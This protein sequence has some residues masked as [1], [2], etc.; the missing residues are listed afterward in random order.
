M[1]YQCP[2]PLAEAMEDRI[3]HSA[4]LLPAGL[5]ADG[6]A[7]V[8]EQR[9]ELPAQPQTTVAALATQRQ[10][11]FVDARA[12]AG[13]PAGWA[14]GDEV[15][16][17]GAGEDGLARI[18][19][20]LANRHDL[21][22]VHLLP[23]DSSGT[24]R[25]GDTPFDAGTLLARAAEVAGWGDA[26]GADGHLVLHRQAAATPGTAA[27]ATGMLQ[28]DLA[29][30]TGANV[31]MVVDNAA[32]APA[33][34][35]VPQ[36]SGRPPLNFET[37]LGQA[38]AG[39]DF[40]AR[41]AGY[42]LAL[43]DGNAT[44]QLHAGATSAT[45][46]MALVGAAP[47]PA[48]LAEGAITSR[49]NYLVGAPGQ[50]WQNVENH[51]SVRYDGVYDG[52]DLRYY[53]S[54]QQLEYDFIVGAGAD[55]RQIALRFDGAEQVAIDAD[56]AL[57]LTLAGGGRALFHAPVSYQDGA[58]G[59]EVVASR[60]LL[61]ADGSVGFEV[62]AYDHTRALVIDP[63]LA[64]GTYFGDAGAEQM[65]G[66]ALGADGTVYLA[67]SDNGDAVVVK[68]SADL[69]SVVYTTYIG[70]GASDSANAIAVDAA[71]Q[72]YIA[73]TTNSP[74]F[75]GSVS[76]GTD[77]F[78]AKLSVD[79]SSLLY[80]RVVS[81]GL[82]DQGNGIAVDASG[83]AYLVA[84][85]G[86][87]IA[88]DISVTKFNAAGSAA[89]YSFTIAG[90]GADTGLAIAV[91]GSGR[92]AIT[93]HTESTDLGASL[94][95]AFNTSLGNSHDAY[96]FQLNA[97]GNA[98]VYGTLFGGNQTDTGRAITYGPGGRIYIT[99]DTDSTNLSTTSGAFQTSF[100]N[101]IEAFV[102]VFDPALSG[103][104]TRV[105]AT[106]LSGNG[107][108]IGRAIAV[109]G[110]G[111]IFVAGSTD[112]TG[113]TVTADRAQGSNGGL[114]DG[115]FAILNPAGAGSADLVYRSYLGGTG[116][117]DAN[118]LALGS[119]KVV[120]AG[121]SASATGIAR[122]GGADTSFAGATDGFA[123]SFNLAATLIVD[124]NNDLI[125]GNVS[126]IAALL[127][128]RGADGKVSL[129][130][131]ITAANNTAN[132]AGGAD[133]ILF[134]I[135]AG[136]LQ[137]INLGST[138]PDITQALVIDGSSQGGWNGAPLIEL[139]GSGADG[140]NFGLSI[141]G[142]GSTV[143]G[144]VINQFKSG[145]IALTGGG[146]NLIAGNYIGL[147]A[148]GT[149][150]A[151]NNKDG[152][153]I[154]SA[155]NTIGGTTAADRNVISG[156]GWSG[157]E[158]WRASATG[159]II[160]GNYIG[161][162]AAGTAALG[163]NDN[164]IVSGSNA[165]SNTIGGSAVGAGNVIA[166]H[167]LTVNSDGIRINGGSGGTIAGNRIGTDPSGTVALPN[168]RNGII[169]K[170][171]SNYTVGGTAAG[172]GNL[173]ANSGAAGVVIADSGSAN[174]VLGNSIYGNTTLGIDLGDDGLTPNDGAQT[175][176]SP[177]LLSDAPVLRGAALN[178]STLTVD[179]Y[180][181]SAAGQALF[182]GAR[183][184]VFVA[185]P[186]ASG[187]GEG[188]TYLGSL[189]TDA[190]GNF[191]GSLTVAGVS[192]GATLTATATDVAGN[193]SEF[194]ANRLV[195]LR[196]SAPVLAGANALSPI[197]EDD[198]SNSGTLVSELIA[199]RVSDAD[200]S[201]LTGIAV[202]AVDNSSGAW[203]YSSNSGGTWAAFGTPATGSARLL[204]ADAGTLVR[205]VPNANWNGTL[206]AGIT[207]QAWD[208]TS[209]TVGLTA[210][211][212]TGGGSTAFSLASAS[213]ALS[214]TAVND[215]PIASGGASLLAVAEDTLSPTGATVA[216][217]YAGN[218]SDA[219]DAGS[220]TGIVVRG[221][222]VDAGEGRWQYSIDAGSSWADFGFISDTSSLSLG[223]AD[224]LRFMPTADYNGTPNNLSVRLVDN[225]VAVS[226]GATVDASSFGGA[227]AFSAATVVTSTS[228]L[229]V[230]DA[231]VGA[232]SSV[233]TGQDT[234]RTLTRADFGFADTHGESNSFASV[235]LQPPSVAGTL[236]LAG[237]AVNSATEVTVAQLDAGSL[238]FTPLAGASGNNYATIGF[239]VRDSGGTANGGVDLD[240]V[241][242]TL[243]INVTATGTVAGQIWFSTAGAVVSAGGTGWAAGQIVQFGDAGDTFDINA[244]TTSGTVNVLA[245]F[246]APVPMRGL[247][248]VQS[249]LTLGTTGTQFTLNPGDL[250]M[251]LDP[252]AAPATVALNG[253]AL[254]V[255]RRDI[256]VFRPSV[257]GNYASGTY[258]MLLDNGI[259]DAA[260]TVGTPPYNVHA[261]SIVETDTTVGGTVLPAGT[262][263]LSYSTKAI[264]NNIYTTTVIGTGAGASTQTTDT[265]L[266]I[267]GYTLGLNNAPT[268]PFQIQGLHLL[269]QATAFNG[270]TL[271]TGTLLVA[272]NGI[273]TY[274]GVAQDSFDVVALTVTRT[275]QNGGTV[276][277]GQ[278]LFDGSDIGLTAA[279]DPAASNINSLT[280]FGGAA[281]NTPPTVTSA[282]TASIFEGVAL[283]HT[284]TATDPELQA[285]TFTV[286]GGS[287]G[288]RFTIDGSNRLLFT[289]AP[290][291]DAPVDA[292][293]NNVYLV[294]VRASDSN[295]AS[296]LQTISVTVRN[297]NEAPLG[298]DRTVTVLE[299]GVYTFGAADFGFSD[300]SDVPANALLEVRIASL[301]AAGTLRNNGAAV[302]LGQMVSATDIGLG[303]LRFTPVANANGANYA[304]FDFQLRDDGGVVGGGVD[305]E[306]GTHT[307]VID[308]TPVNDPPTGLPAITGTTTEDQLLTAD[309]SAVADADALGLFSYQWSRGGSSVS[310][311]TG[312]TYLLGD[313]DV[314]AQ[315]T[316]RVSYTDGQ[317]TVET[318]ASNP[319]VAVA[320][321]NDTPGG[322][323]TING[324]ATEDQTLSVDT[325]AITDADGLGAF[326][327]QWLRGGSMVV[328]ATG[329]TYLL[330]DA[331]VGAVI[332]AQVSYVDGQGT[333]ETLTSSPTSPVANLNDAPTGLPAVTGIVAEDQIV[334]VDTAAIAD[335]DGLGLF[336]YQWLRGGSAVVGATAA[337]YLL[338]DAD[339]GSLISVSVSYIDLQGTVETLASAAVVVA[340]I[341]DAPAG[342]PLVA[343]AAI[344][345]QTLSA[346][347]AAI[348]DADGL[349][350]FNYQWLRDNV[351]VVGATGATYLL[352]DADVVAQ[353]SV[354]VSYTDG[355]G[356]FETL[357]SAPTAP[358]LNI[359]D[360][361]TG[362]LLASGGAVNGQT[363]SADAS[364]IGDADG[365]GTLNYQW[366]R[367]G[368]A[369]GGATGSTYLLGDADVG[370][371]LS[372]RVT[373]TDAHG[374]VESLGSAP[375]AAVANTNDAPVLV[376]ALAD[377]QGTV[378]E[379]MRF[380]LPAASFAD[381]DSGD[382]LRYVATLADGS[383][384]PAWL[385][386]DADELRFTGTP[387]DAQVGTFLVRITATDLAGAA[388]QALF[389]VTVAPAPAVFVEP[390]ALANAPLAAPGNPP[391][392]VASAKPASADA[393]A[394]AANVLSEPASE[395][396]QGNDSLAGAVP[397]VA[398]TDPTRVTA[399]TAVEAGD[400]MRPASRAD[401]V[402]ASA[403][404]PQFSDIASSSTTQ[405]L[406]S[407]ELVR[408]LE[409]VQRRMLE[410]GDERRTAIASSIV[411][412]SGVSVGYVVW[413]VRGGVLMSSMLSALPAWQM[414]DPMPVLAAARAAKGRLRKTQAED[415]EVERL[416][417]G[418]STKTA[419]KAAAARARDAIRSDRQPDHTELH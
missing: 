283:V 267:N 293:G 84:T 285:V 380:T 212:A 252:G 210:D 369:V 117:D 262:I 76:T 214:V 322:S 336:S 281:T 220:L 32:T 351:A 106:Y 136:G 98:V 67:G 364:G 202:T 230:N 190:S 226:S 42:A 316:V 29:A 326:S 175:A 355:Q 211:A 99:G 238:V 353:M 125:D 156:N 259:H 408:R 383:A 52:I 265:Q 382:T 30:L 4:D 127:A 3:L 36:Q 234:S 244:G 402:L 271:A 131:A 400:A 118:A 348:T 133:R 54:G 48:A 228:V 189:T 184:E 185:A 83:Q 290:D 150:A 258:F 161:L 253:G 34:A 308:V 104:A 74:L 254:V 272:V 342:A 79:G 345:D 325:S 363:L 223:L 194:G 86:T 124:T 291:F 367:G 256:V 200:P 330:G 208:Q 237:S 61:A 323:P 24:L 123:V 43:Q 73:G 78:A 154:E 178:G 199:G 314:G 103:S 102:A 398:S 229:S 334:S 274:A 187:Y 138:L 231:P 419:K 149:T 70:G 305:L 350:A 55:W 413:L 338:G 25:L 196:N 395:L 37:N 282:A 418:D 266:L 388:A 273:G 47:D 10:I 174:R 360:T 239:Q 280:V 412:T 315:I 329:A 41:G 80:T 134:S 146:N 82:S 160:Q 344:E 365:L 69:A 405:F 319:T 107:D 139:N 114:T 222:S 204:A 120:L 64:Y 31:D 60:Y 343:G 140:A 331:D 49:T 207:F 145:G 379:V 180:V 276:A 309:A 137:T 328:G 163:N 110:A 72:V 142:G 320:G 38:A 193:S 332:R 164:G 339:A 347:T 284:L 209:G 358:V 392:A 119:G 144:L 269:T 113:L 376:R 295:G 299:D 179:G 2:R 378:S 141:T 15:V 298:A 411:M 249:T 53:G 122:A 203:Q 416:F 235:L 182:A 217:L 89:L 197:N 109:D 247:H 240:P 75:Y 130:E 417:D 386:F 297:L 111:Q 1:T 172:A 306:P 5:L 287:D 310:G 356:T 394:P 357:T 88:T 56:G 18:S 171:T 167:N 302:A 112:S 148:S 286:A 9:L 289:S 393:G 206:A 177:N 218:F 17:I 307:L 63:T 246:S 248:Y 92:A 152:I 46:H 227:T 35:A 362:V 255:D 404:V 368:S 116:N 377:R 181:G 292:D 407:D 317:G 108:D 8:V 414:V 409:E 126:S 33:V 410:Q 90:N 170:G 27:T 162:N 213:A 129:R 201:A 373:Y 77:A 155:N 176:G 186:D 6:S 381:A 51:A 341:N 219:A 261:I 224:R 294:Q 385:S 245:G 303:R 198:S 19:A 384:L 143:R 321:V 91:D 153:Y 390:P 257:A 370:S 349:G 128:N 387:A 165:A 168:S 241:Q 406:R 28:S 93:G 415:G 251:V 396:A 97:A 352:G 277:T 312:S 147:S 191:S 300:P 337:S 250:V 50:W 232:S 95:N 301:P 188:K 205:F 173:I 14:S 94:V 318:L 359:N 296:V 66:V 58:N 81:G 333:V 68:L 270:T 215:A 11:V 366:L 45:L 399:A 313:A 157:I 135:G 22:A 243:G 216:A 397:F 85:V 340:N 263:V 327:F 44:L 87:G 236:R 57:Q 324:V 225:S 361:P 275:E 166:G 304:S 105:Y 40:I 12:A 23:D 354:E 159:N 121:T 391:A 96:V 65:R 20:A 389:R 403:L 183:I 100:N 374:T 279:S 71:G 371:Q 195:T 221:Q 375:T 311:A 242:R 16:T 268:D 401:S 192:V 62:G 7:G 13:A 278:L 260:P 346:A 132:T 288:T 372:V 169:L 115:F 59:R 158:L 26:I 335:A 264:H 101:S 39:I 21:A 151:G 233:T